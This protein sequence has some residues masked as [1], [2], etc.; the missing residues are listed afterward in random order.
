MPPTDAEIIAARLS[1]MKGLI[2]A[3]EKACSA[4]TDLTELFRKLREEL[5]AAREALKIVPSP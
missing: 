2:D 3:L 5:K 4:N 1:R